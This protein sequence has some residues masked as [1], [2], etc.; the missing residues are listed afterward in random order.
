MKSLA[1]TIP[2]VSYVLKSK[3]NFLVWKLYNKDSKDND[4]SLQKE[5]KNKLIIN[6]LMFFN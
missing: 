4:I 2:K 1:Y 5:S 6:Y 3:L